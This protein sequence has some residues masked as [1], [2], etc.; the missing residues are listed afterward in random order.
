MQALLAEKLDK[1]AEL[2]ALK[3]LAQELGE[4][5]Q[6]AAAQQ[7]EALAE[8]LRA[9]DEALRESNGVLLERVGEHGSGV[10]QRVAALQGCMQSVQDA[11]EELKLLLEAQQQ[12]STLHEEEVKRVVAALHDSHRQLAATSEQ[13]LKA[14]AELL[15][16]KLGDM[17]ADREASVQARK[18]RL[19]AGVQATT[20]RK[21]ASS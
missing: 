4:Q 17:K 7:Q 2:E 8:H 11:D 3:R 14:H 20:G 16:S 10:E 19:E 21:H 18:E 15:A 9:V 1:T 5:Q 13:A 12:V 6:G